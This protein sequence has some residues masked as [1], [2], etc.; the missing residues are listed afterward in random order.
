LSVLR[1]T[2]R[3]SKTLLMFVK[4]KFFPKIEEVQS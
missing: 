1:Q 4:W 3:N 2:L